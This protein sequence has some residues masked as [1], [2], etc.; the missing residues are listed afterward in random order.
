MAD[1]FA[2]AADAEVVAADACE[3][4]FVAEAHRAKARTLSA[5]LRF[6]LEVARLRQA[7]LSY[8]KEFSEIGGFA[9][10]T[11]FGTVASEAVDGTGL[12]GACV[13]V[14]EESSRTCFVADVIRAEVPGL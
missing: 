5:C 3:T 13:A 10:E 2:G 4:H 1:A 9:A 11:V 12:T 6:V 7:A 14:C 8:T